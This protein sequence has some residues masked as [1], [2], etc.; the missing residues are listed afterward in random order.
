MSEQTER[1]IHILWCRVQ[2]LQEYVLD[3][4]KKIEDLEKKIK[5]L[6]ESEGTD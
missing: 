4:S 5:T 3:N 1:V 6:K 2:E